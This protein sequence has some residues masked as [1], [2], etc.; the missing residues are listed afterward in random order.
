MTYL[1]T[2][3]IETIERL[4]GTKLSALTQDQL[5]GIDQFHAGGPEAVDRLIPSLRLTGEMTAL[6]IGSGLGGP[7]RQIARAAGCDVVGVDIT[8]SYVAAALDL[9][10]SAGLADRVQFF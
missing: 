7:A 10:R 4:A 3:I 6:D 2:G 1:E 5:D 9:T 8:P